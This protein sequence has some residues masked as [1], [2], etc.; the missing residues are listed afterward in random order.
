MIR[1]TTLAVT[2][3][4]LSTFVTTIGCGDD[5]A[6][7]P[8]TVA[9][10]TPKAKPSP[11]AAKAAKVAEVKA[12]TEGSQKPGDGGAPPKAAKAAKATKVADV[13]AAKAAK[14]K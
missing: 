10:P 9:K 5:P 4:A 11:K 1:A 7:A 14:S 8:A 3:A 13:K 2:I 12:K 6:P